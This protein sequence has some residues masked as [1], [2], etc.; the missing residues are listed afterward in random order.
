ML[1]GLE[2]T[3]EK[4]LPPGDRR[5]HVSENQSQYGQ[6]TELCTPGWP[7]LRDRRNRLTIAATIADHEGDEIVHRYRRRHRCPISHSYEK[8]DGACEHQRL[9]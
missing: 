2:K 5:W 7:C 1:N 3:L 8:P 9:A 6:N 4:K